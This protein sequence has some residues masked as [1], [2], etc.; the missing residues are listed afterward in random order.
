MPTDTPN[1]ASSRLEQSIHL[2]PAGKL[3]KMIATALSTRSEQTGDPWAPPLPR[4]LDF[5]QV[6]H[7]P[8]GEQVVTAGIVTADGVPTY[9]FQVAYGIQSAPLATYDQLEIVFEDPAEHY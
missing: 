9:R 8:D 5:V 7:D 2:R 3:R 4:E 6:D 1:E